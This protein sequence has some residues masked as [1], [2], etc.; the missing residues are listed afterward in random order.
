MFGILDVVILYTK[1]GG[2]GGLKCCP[3]VLLV[4]FLAILVIKEAK[5]ATKSVN[6]VV[7][8]VIQIPKRYATPVTKKLTD[9]TA[10]E[11]Q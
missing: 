8:R 6:E 9:L 7:A 3:C 11:R 10:S 5:I 2:L 1:R 4:V